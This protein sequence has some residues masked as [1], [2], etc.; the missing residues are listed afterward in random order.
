MKISVTDYKFT[1]NS[2]IETLALL[3][4]WHNMDNQHGERTAVMSLKIASRMDKPLRGEETMIL[5]YAARLHD[6]GR[7]GIDDDIMF[8]AGPLTTAERGA[9]ETHPA[10]GYN[11]LKR[12]NLP[13]EITETILYHHE[14]FDGTGY[15]K[16]LKGLEIPL[17]ARIIHISDTWDALTEDR[18]YRKAMDFSAALNAMN[19]NVSHFDPEL[20]AIFLDII[21]EEDRQPHAG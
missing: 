7:V 16:K 8:K 20:Y 3:G 15:P 9:I 6:L 17:F 2:L 13:K 5:D 12:S 4:N 10:I 18:P 11:F 19:V 14:N 1:L 21:K